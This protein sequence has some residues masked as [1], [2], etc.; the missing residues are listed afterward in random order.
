MTTIEIDPEEI[1]VMVAE[2]IASRVISTIPGNTTTSPLYKM[3]KF[4][5]QKKV[6]QYLYEKMKEEI[7]HA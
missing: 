3:A 2:I 7:D 6:E 1:K 5:A 4:N